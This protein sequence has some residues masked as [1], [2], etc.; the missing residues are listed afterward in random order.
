MQNTSSLYRQIVSELNHWYE[1][2]VD[3]NGVEYGEDKIFELSTNI[4]MFDADPE[5]GKAVAAEIDLTILAPNASIPRRARIVPY[6]RVCTNRE[7]EPD[8]SFDGD[9]IDFGSNAELDGDILVL[10]NAFLSNDIV[11]FRNSTERVESDWLQKGVFYIDTRQVTKNSDGLDVLTIH[12]YD[13]MLF[14]E[15]DFADTDRDWPSQGVLDTTIVSDIAATMNVSVDERT[16]DIMTDGNRLP[17]PSG[18]TLREILGY[19]ASMYVGSFVMTDVGKLR[20]V[21][22]T[23]LPPETSYLIDDGGYAITFGG[24]RILV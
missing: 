8:V 12:G 19:I 2:K 4:S 9:Y 6:V 11:Y 16:W 5:V 15:Q 22:L 13:A 3:I 23:E 17:L 1:V 10:N 18:Y 14:A 21:T 7:T 20:L 24:E